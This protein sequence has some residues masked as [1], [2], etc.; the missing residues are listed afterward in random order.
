MID[1]GRGVTCTMPPSTQRRKSERGEY[2][3]SIRGYYD[4]QRVCIYN[5]HGKGSHLHHASIHQRG[6][7][8]A[9]VSEACAGDSV[10]SERRLVMIGEGVMV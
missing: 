10:Q 9:A 8:C 2:I 5:R 3:M 4:K 6:H 7:L 1:T